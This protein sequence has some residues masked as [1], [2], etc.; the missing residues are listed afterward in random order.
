MGMSSPQQNG[1]ESFMEK[2]YSL[3]M[4]TN[5]APDHLLR[6]VRCQ[7]KAGDVANR[8][9]ALAES[10]ACSA[11]KPVRIAAGNAQIACVYL[12]F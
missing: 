7:C 12:V 3:K 5:F 9:I 10:M 8:L 11:Q 1:D 6:V 2:C 4:D